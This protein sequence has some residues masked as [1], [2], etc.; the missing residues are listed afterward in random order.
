MALV[1]SVTR[2]ILC[3]CLCLVPGAHKYSI[4]C[5]PTASP[6]R[7]STLLR[8]LLSDF[9]LF[10][11]AFLQLKTRAHECRTL[12][13]VSVLFRIIQDSRLSAEGCNWCLTRVVRGTRACQ[14]TPQSD[15]DPTAYC[16]RRTCHHSDLLEFP[17]NNRLGSGRRVSQD[18][19]TPERS[20][21]P[22]GT[23]VADLTLA[24]DL[25]AGNAN[26]G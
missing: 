24:L 10:S 16:A 25:K 19:P 2:L 8:P 18:Q 5:V 26:P 17:K 9:L 6:S 20:D 1:F 12:V 22:G 15:N 3:V 23:V 14:Q 7:P 13:V 21:Q 11:V 4:V